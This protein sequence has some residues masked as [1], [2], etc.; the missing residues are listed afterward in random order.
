MITSDWNMGINLEFL[1]TTVE[2]I[3]NNLITYSFNWPM[4][5]ISNSTFKIKISATNFWFDQSV[6]ETVVWNDLMKNIFWT[7][8]ITSL[9]PNE[10]VPYSIFLWDL[11]WSFTNKVPFHLEATTWL[12]QSKVIME[13]KIINRVRVVGSFTDFSNFKRRNNCTLLISSNFIKKKILVKLGKSEK[14]SPNFDF[15]IPITKTKKEPARS[16]GLKWSSNIY[17]IKYIPKMLTF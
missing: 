14:F 7:F 2:I 10:K 8:E 9:P 13:W 16:A 5:M 3:P 12:F 6:S 15:V 1:R 11:T 17:I 4:K